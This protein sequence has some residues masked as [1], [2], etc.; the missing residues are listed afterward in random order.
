MPRPG[1]RV[2]VLVPAAQSIRGYGVGADVAESVMSCN[3]PATLW[4][5]PVGVTPGNLKRKMSF[6]LEVAP[7]LCSAFLN[8]C[9]T[10]NHVGDRDR[11]HHVGGRIGPAL[12]PCSRSPPHPSCW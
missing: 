3:S 4:S 9:G 7:S 8:L 6:N 5:L 12:F 11:I 2:F 1:S 10:G